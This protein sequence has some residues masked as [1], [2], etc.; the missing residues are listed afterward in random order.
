MADRTLTI[1]HADGDSETYTIKRD[2]FA[3]V[4]E[5]SRGHVYPTIASG[6]YNVTGVTFQKLPLGNAD[7]R[8]FTLV[9]N[10]ST[11]KRYV[12]FVT[13]SNGIRTGKHRIAFDLTLNSGSIGTITGYHTDRDADPSNGGSYAPYV[14]TEGSN[15][16]DFEIAAPYRPCIG[17]KI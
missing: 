5:M 1:N 4:R 11:A 12:S 10:N 7:E 17:I 2:K 3:G 6:S 16:I 8:T 13:G 15:V 14:V 9:A